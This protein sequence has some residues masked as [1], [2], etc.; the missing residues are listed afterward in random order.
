MP[1]ISGTISGSIKGIA[2]NVP[3]KI[4]S[5]SLWDRSGGGAIVN[6]GVVVSGRDI[7]FK[8]IT[9]SAGGSDDEAT[10][11]N[12]LAGSQ[13]LIVSNATVDYYFSLDD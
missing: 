11:I 3:S 13:I 9:L 10:D 2:L 8:T 12:V 4:I 7:Y 6:L 5:F 1:I